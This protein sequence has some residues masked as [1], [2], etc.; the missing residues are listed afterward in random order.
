MA[1]PFK[2]NSITNVKNRFAFTSKQKHGGLKRFQ[3]NLEI[4]FVKIVHS[5]NAMTPKAILP[6]N[7]PINVP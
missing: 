7:S 2:F 4:P 6:I 3:Y 5:L 1:V